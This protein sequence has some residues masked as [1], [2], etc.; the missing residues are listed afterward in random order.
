MNFDIALHQFRLRMHA[1]G[2]GP[3][4]AEKRIDKAIVSVE[5]GRPSCESYIEEIMLPWLVFEDYGQICEGPAEIH[6]PKEDD[7]P[8]RG[9]LMIVPQFA[10]AKYRMDFALVSRIGL[11]TRIVCVECDGAA[12]HGDPQKDFRRDAYLAAWGIPTVRINPTELREYPRRASRRCARMI[13][14]LVG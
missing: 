12:F 13:S 10:F 3:E 14:D 11:V 5:R 7:I 8:P 9:P 6:L 1:I 2:M 4:Q